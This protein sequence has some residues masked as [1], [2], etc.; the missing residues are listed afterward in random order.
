M[1]LKEGISY[2][3]ELNETVKRV[4]S[5]YQEIS[6]NLE[7]ATISYKWT[8]HDFISQFNSLPEKQAKADYYYLLN[9]VYAKFLR[10]LKDINENL[11]KAE[12]DLMNYREEENLWLNL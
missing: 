2:E 3:Y 6:E 10:Q 5:L 4:E 1:V 8:I 9:N 12:D 11:I 7:S